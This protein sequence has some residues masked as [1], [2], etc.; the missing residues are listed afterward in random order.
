M[1]HLNLQR[2]L[3]IDR[4]HDMI[5][6]SRKIMREQKKTEQKKMDEKKM[7]KAHDSN[8]EILSGKFPKNTS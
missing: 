7:D 8:M 1:T 6:E 5:E 3:A 4:L 2:E